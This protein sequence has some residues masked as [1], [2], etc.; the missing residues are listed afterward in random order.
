VVIAIYDVSGARVPTLVDAVQEPNRY[1]VTW[2]GKNEAGKAMTSGVY[3]VRYR[4][5]SH[6]FTKKAV[7]LR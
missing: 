6:S 2:D 7:L 1:V 5:G 3:F 4:A